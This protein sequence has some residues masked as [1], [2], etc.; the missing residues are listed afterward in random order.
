MSRAGRPNTNRYRQIDPSVTRDLGQPTAAV[1]ASVQTVP[2]ESA[3]VQVNFA[4]PVVLRAGGSGMGWT[5]GGHAFSAT[6]SQSTDLRSV[7]VAFDDDVDAGDTFTTPADIT[8]RQQYVT[9][10]AGTTPATAIAVV[11]P[12]EANTIVITNV[13]PLT[14]TAVR[15]EFETVIAMLAAGFETPN[16]AGLVIGS[17]TTLNGFQAFDDDNRMD[18]DLYG[19]TVTS[20]DAWVFT[21]P[22]VQQWVSISGARVKACSGTVDPA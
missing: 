20:G 12:P 21:P 4:Q 3:Q 22:G 9:F 8:N 1:I 16:L 14:T 15:V 11:T 10:S 6:L 5:C 17:A 18:F 13:I 7:I 2:G 19:G